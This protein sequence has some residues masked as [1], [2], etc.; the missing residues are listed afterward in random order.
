MPAKLDLNSEIAGV[1][2]GPTSVDLDI[3]QFETFAIS[4]EYSVGGMGDLI[5]QA[6]TDRIN[7]ATI[8]GTTQAVDVGGGTHIWNCCNMRFLSLRI[9]IPD[10]DTVSIRFQAGRLNSKES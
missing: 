10:I 4:V 2:V 7:F 5:L 1:L 8:P 6:S 9:V 3:Y